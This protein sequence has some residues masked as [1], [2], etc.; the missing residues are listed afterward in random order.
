MGK[1]MLLV[2]IGGF[3]GSVFRF[4]CY[5]FIDKFFLGSFPFGTFTV[6]VVGSL[7]IGVAYGLSFKENFFG[8][9]WRI[10]FVA[11]FC[12]GFTTFSAFSY[13]N[14]AL[15]QSGHFISVLL[16][17]SGNIFLGVLATYL[18]LILTK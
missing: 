12:G 18:G 13:D 15:L 4:L 5:Q 7:L 8:P 17:V 9:E 3:I 6:N 1:V 14:L 16:Y 2:G 10:F 11:G